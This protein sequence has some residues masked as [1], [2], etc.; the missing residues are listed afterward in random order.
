[1]P[2]AE[3]SKYAFDDVL[4]VQNAPLAIADTRGKI[5]WYNNSFKKNF[6]QGRIK[7]YSVP[8]LFALNE[9][10]YLSKLNSHNSFE[11][12]RA[13]CRERV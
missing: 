8:K 13:S 5:I 9:D 6:K 11:I 4:E 2:T 12:G 1:M 10:E 3:K 7:G